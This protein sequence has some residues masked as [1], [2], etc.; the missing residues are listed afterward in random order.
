[1]APARRTTG[2]TWRNQVCLANV[3]L[4]YQNE[5]A[6]TIPR[7]NPRRVMEYGPPGPN[8]FCGPMVPQRTEA[9]KKVFIWGQVNLLGASTVQTPGILFIWTR[10]MYEFLLHYRYRKLQTQ[11]IEISSAYLEV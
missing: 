9:V 7:G 11:G 8:V 5:T 2:W 3:R 6:R 1:M 4:A 10:G